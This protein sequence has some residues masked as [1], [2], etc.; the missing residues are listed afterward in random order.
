MGAFWDEPM[1]LSSVLN[2]IYLPKHDPSKCYTHKKSKGMGRNN[3]E[4][5]LRA[6]C[7]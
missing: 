2:L 3:V 4:G 1:D 5:F 7:S 6:V